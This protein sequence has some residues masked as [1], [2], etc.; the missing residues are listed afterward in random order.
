MNILQLDI[1][2]ARVLDLYAGTG[3]LGLEALSRGAARVD[4]VDSD[5]ESLRLVTENVAGLGAVARCAVHRDDAIE[6][7]SRLAPAGNRAPYDLTF[8]DP[9]Y[10]QGIAKQLAM[11]W[12]DRRFSTILCVEHEASES[13]PA[14]GDSRRYG[15]TSVTFYRS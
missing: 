8:A 10:R 13:L 4:F 9:P 1:P 2:E 3:A 7:V 5:P 6:F 12:L 14:G 11:L 15:T